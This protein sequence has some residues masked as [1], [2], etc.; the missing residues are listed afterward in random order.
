VIEGFGE[1]SRV[2][3]WIFERCD[4]S[5]NAVETP[6]GFVPKPGAIDLQ[7]LDVNAN[8]MK[9]LFKV[10]HEEWNKEADELAEYFKIYGDKFPDA[11]NK[12]L[13]SLKQR[14]AK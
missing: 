14:L 6:I 8:D 3:K 7:G 12:E 11:L 10:D 4:G 13:Q 5:T 2:L 1:N 9:E